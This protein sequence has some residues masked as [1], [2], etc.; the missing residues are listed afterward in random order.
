MSLFNRVS[1]PRGPST[2]ANPGNKPVCNF[3]LEGRCKFGD[4]C[5]FYHPPRDSNTTRPGQSL[6]YHLSVEGIKSDLTPGDERPSWPLS[7]YGPGKDAPR[8]LLE[9]A[10]EQSPEELRVQYYLVAATGAAEQYQLTETEALSQANAQAQ[11]ILSDLNGAVKYI[12]DGKDIHPNRDDS[13]VKNVGNFPR[14]ER[15]DMGRAVV[16]GAPGGGGGFGQSSNFGAASTGAFGQTNA[17]PNSAFGQPAAFGSSGGMESQPATGSSAF[18]QPS[19]LRPQTA[20]FG[21]GSAFGAPSSLGQS[22]SAF[23]APSALG[24]STSAFGKPSPLGGSAFGQPSA[25][26]GSS[27][28]GG[29]AASNTQGSAFGQASSLGSAQGSA[30][31][32][33]SSLGTGGSTFGKPSPFGAAASSTTTPAFG[34]STPFGAAAPTTSSAFGQPSAPA[35]T[36]SPFGQTSNTPQ[37]SPFGQASNTTPFGQASTPTPFGQASTQQQQGSVFGQPSAPNNTQQSSFG[38]P[39]P[40]GST[41]AP[42]PS[43]FAQQSQPSQPSPFASTTPAAP[44]PF[45]QKQQQQ[46]APT[47]FK[48]HPITTNPTTKTSYYTHPHHRRPERIWHPDGPPGPNPDAEAADPS[49]YDSGKLGEVLKQIYEYVRGNGR[50]EAGVPVPEVPPRREWVGWEV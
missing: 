9:G 4:N 1:N 44:S 33:S 30:F 39:S 7:A 47:S 17:Q 28:F 37:Q 50:F 22:G 2:G 45:A 34:S 36:Q 14:K 49:V 24:S 42:S 21:G 25:M 6:P 41:S 26:G 5:R 46:L 11:Q 29:Q 23:G 20:A 35:Q 32:Q 38:K 40:F 16:S 12:I 27:P 13:V 48:N 10:L 19:N 43:P 3:Y 8:Q 18:G 31:G 15:L